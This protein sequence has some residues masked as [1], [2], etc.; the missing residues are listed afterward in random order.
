MLPQP[1]PFRLF[2]IFQIFKSLRNI[3]HS[4]ACI[5]S[6]LMA[7]MVPLRQ[8]Q[9]MKSSATQKRTGVA[10]VIHSSFR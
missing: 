5:S 1:W 8:Q 3:D 6:P 9:R 10:T 7:V 4:Y 2:G